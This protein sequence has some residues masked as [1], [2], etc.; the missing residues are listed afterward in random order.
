[1]SKQYNLWLEPE[2][3]EMSQYSFRGLD[4]AYEKGYEL[5]KKNVR[6]IRNL[7]LSE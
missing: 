2:L 4:Y 5:G 3:G 1:M 7:L 6:R